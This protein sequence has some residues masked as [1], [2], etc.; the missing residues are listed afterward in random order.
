LAACRPDREL[1]VRL[2]EDGAPAQA[3]IEIANAAARLLRRRVARIGFSSP[4][5]GIVSFSRHGVMTGWSQNGDV[6]LG[7]LDRPGALSTVQYAGRQ[8][9]DR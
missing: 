8:W 9:H 3:I 2:L 5:G 6:N 1:E 7:T 4:G